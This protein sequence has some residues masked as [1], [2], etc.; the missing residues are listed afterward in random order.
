[1]CIRDRFDLT[2][3]APGVVIQ[4]ADTL[5][6]GTE[7]VYSITSRGARPIIVVA[8]PT[9]QSDLALDV[10]GA[11]NALLTTANYGGAGGAETVSYTHLDVYKRQR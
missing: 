5:A 1:M 11:D 10:I 2:T 3:P 7:K 6:A 4:Q 9:D 8:D